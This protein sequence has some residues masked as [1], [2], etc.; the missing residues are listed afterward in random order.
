MWLQMMRRGMVPPVLNSLGPITDWLSSKMINSF[1]TKYDE[2]SRASSA[3]KVGRSAR[4]SIY[5][6]AGYAMCETSLEP[7]LHHDDAEPLLT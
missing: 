5:M 7:I 1:S 3:A 6:C 2:V 4:K